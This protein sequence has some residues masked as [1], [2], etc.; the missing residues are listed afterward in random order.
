MI[1]RHC[2]LFDI[3]FRWSSNKRRFD[4]RE[5]MALVPNCRVRQSKPA[6]PGSSCNIRAKT[7]LK[8]KKRKKKK[9]EKK[10]KKK[11][12]GLKLQWLRF[13]PLLILA[14]TKTRE[15]QR[16]NGDKNGNFEGRHGKTTT[17]QNPPKQ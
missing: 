4:E 7:S 10:K 2:A 16:L 6:I 13:I 8:K 12:R 15:T 9:K 14:V 1:L 11:K 17:N 5:V 3:T